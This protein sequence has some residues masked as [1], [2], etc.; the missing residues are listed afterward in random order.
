MRDDF[1]YL[2]HILLS[3][4]KIKE[5][6]KDLSK[7]DFDSNELVQDAIIRNI[8]IIGEATKKISKELKSKYKEIPWRE[9]SGMRDKLIHD[10]MGIDVD[11]VW[12]T[13]T[14][15]IPLIENLINKIYK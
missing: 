12:K 11:V 8:E 3:I 15:D 5:Y 1:S 10:Y 13:L 9:M 7:T 6:S 4:T 2:E 14:D